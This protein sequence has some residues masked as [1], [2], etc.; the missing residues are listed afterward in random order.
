MQLARVVFLLTCSLP[1][2]AWGPEGHSLIARIAEA[3]LKPAV[4]ARVV[5][6]LGPGKNMSSVASWADEVRRSRPET[7]PW[8]YVDIPIGEA[9]FDMGR[10]CAGGACIVAAIAAMEQKLRDPAAD[11][12][13]RRE[14]LMFLIHFVGDMHQPLHCSDHDDKGGNSVPVIYRDR[15]T[16]LHSA[17]DSGLLG[18]L[19]KEEDLF[20]ALSQESARHRKK[21][22]KG[23]V[24]DWV[25]S[26]HE[27]AKKTVYGLLPKAAEGAPSNVD[28][29]YERAADALIRQQIELGGARLAK[30]LNQALR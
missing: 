26:S 12:G 27:S 13:A 11:A 24:R 5:E 29:E 7:G 2:V 6:I 16:S 3:Q 10:D 4:H 1:A 23:S 25:E 22:A 14:A 28:A 19:G 18:N 21:F 9:H 30:V 15:R 20:P 8:H 17:W